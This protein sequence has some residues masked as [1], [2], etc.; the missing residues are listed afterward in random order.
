MPIRDWKA[1]LNRFA[2]QFEG[3]MAQG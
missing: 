2:I 1:A 3:R